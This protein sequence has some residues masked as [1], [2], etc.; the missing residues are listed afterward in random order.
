MG[1]SSNFGNMFSAAGA[2][3]FLPFL[4]M[5]PPQILLNNLLYDAGQLAIPTDR[6]DA[7]QLS[8]PSH[9]DLGLIRRFMLFFGP[10]SSLFDFLAFAVLLGV[11]HAG[12]QLFQTG[13]FVESLATQSLIIFAIRTRRTPLWR[14]RPGGLLALAAVATVAVGVLLPWTPL[15]PLMG[16]QPLPPALLGA[17]GLL[18][19]GYLIVVEAGKRWFFRASASTVAIG[20]WRTHAFRIHRRASRFT[21]GRRPRRAARDQWHRPQGRPPLLRTPGNN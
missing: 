11:F 1:S 10:I 5:L 6:V 21:V 9:W 15:G 16:F 13:W 20:R 17:M 3:A 12:A 19:V 7:E 18:V 14:S 2:S 4:P 8:A